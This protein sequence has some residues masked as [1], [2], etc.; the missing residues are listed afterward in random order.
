MPTSPYVHIEY[1]VSIL[2]QTRPS[3][4]LDIGL[5]NG[6]LGFIARDLL[7]VCLNESYHKRNWRVLIDGIEIFEDYIQDHQ[8][9]IYN[10]IYIG[11]A[12]EVIDRLGSYDMVILGD[13]LEHFDKEKG[14][15]L[16]D[17]CARHSNRYILVNVPLGNWDQPAIYGNEYERHRSVWSMEDFKGFTTCSELFSFNQGE[18]GLFL[19]DKEIYLIHKFLKES[20]ALLQD[21]QYDLAIERL[22][23]ALKLSE[24]HSEV[25]NNLAIAY[26]EKG[27]LEE[28]LSS[29]KKAIEIAPDFYLYHFN[30]ANFYRAKGGFSE[31]IAHYLQAIKLNPTFYQSAFNLGILYKGLS[32]HDEAL[33]AFEIVNE[34]EPHHVDAYINRGAIKHLQGKYDEAL[35]LYN[36]ALS[37]DPGNADAHWNLA[38]TLLLK[39]D[40]KQG[41][42]EYEW[43]WRRKDYPPRQFKIPRWDGVSNSGT[44]LL[45]TEQGF[46]DAIQFVRYAELVK[47]KGLKVYLQCQR[48]LI[49]LFKLIDTIDELYA[50]EQDPIDCDYQFPLMSL[51][52]IFKTEVHN[53]PNRV[54]YINVDDSV[55][56]RAKS[57][58]NASDK[59]K[60]GLVWSAKPEEFHKK[61]MAFELLQPLLDLEDINFYSLQV[62][63]AKGQIKGSDRIIDL[64]P[65]IEDFLDTAGFLA[66]LDLILTVDTATAHLAGAMARPVWIMLPYCPDWRW[67]LH[68]TDSL[69]YP[70]ARLFR[71]SSPGNWTAVIAAIKRELELWL[72]ATSRLV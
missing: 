25:Y 65:Y 37:I 66:N 11:D 14:W 33:V 69:W 13:V 23:Y 67:M 8:R 72:K 68:R 41:W 20:N 53:I 39:G 18:Y 26:S 2:M 17:K 27:M 44:V 3:S 15:L 47:Q 32:L 31:A 59:L 38:M 60:V 12:F 36:K 48:E 46:G 1:V 22:N 9:Y 6:K 58:L 54:P 51:P 30:I 71:Q 50:H 5:G 7:D 34:I 57:V 42:Q 21:R 61:S 62:G 43:R 28:A 35:A 10:N 49:R 56:E 45:Y 64:S 55:R 52:L 63:D 16:L 29:L 70:T 40:F 24:G 4:I 19:I